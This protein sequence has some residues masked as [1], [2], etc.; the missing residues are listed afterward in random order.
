MSDVAQAARADCAFRNGRDRITR[1]GRHLR[2]AVRMVIRAVKMAHH[3]QVS[4]WE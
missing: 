3:E 4:M 2:L 1:A